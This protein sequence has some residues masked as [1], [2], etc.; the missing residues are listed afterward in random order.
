MDRGTIATLLFAALC[1]V[2]IGFL[3]SDFS[4]DA[5]EFDSATRGAV[6][7]GFI[8]G[9]FGLG[10]TLFSISSLKQENRRIEKSKEEENKK[11]KEDEDSAQIR[12]IFLKAWDF[13]EY[14]Q[15]NFEHFETYDHSTK[16]YIASGE[17][18]R[19]FTK[20]LE[21]LYPHIDF[22][23]KERA[24]LLRLGGAALLNFVS[25]AKGLSQSFSFL[26]ERH[27]QAYY[28]LFAIYSKSIDSRKGYELSGNIE[29]NSIELMNMMDVEG[30]F[31]SFLSRATSTSQAFLEKIIEIN[32][33]ITQQAVKY[34]Q[35]G[36]PPSSDNSLRQ[37]LP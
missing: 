13:N 27:K 32:N 3:L 37:S 29:S 24:F 34:E 16:I 33:E 15:K 17:H 1:F 6:A 30:H 26:H 11:I 4:R 28:A 22:S 36:E 25:E 18:E 31:H 20:P 5:I 7:G 21:G 10:A 35:S 19:S 14:I 23:I 8:A 2:L 12:S 9:F